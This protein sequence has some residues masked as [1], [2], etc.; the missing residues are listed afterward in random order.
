MF[1]K[2]G[3]K[4]PKSL[5]DAVSGVMEGK[6]DDLRDRMAEKEREKADDLSKDYTPKKKP[7]TQKVSGG[8]YGG[9]KQKSDDMDE[10][11]DFTGKLL[12]SLKETKEVD[13]D[14]EMTASQ[15][16]KREKIV[17]SMKDKQS[18]FKKKYGNRWKNV[19]YATATKM[20]MK[21]EKEEVD[22]DEKYDARKEHEYNMDAAQREIDRRHSQ[23]EDMTHAYVDKKTYEIKHKKPTKED[24]AD[25]TAIPAQNP[26]RPRLASS[27]SS[28]MPCSNLSTFFS[29][30][31]TVA[32]NLPYLYG[33]GV[34]WSDIV[35]YFRTG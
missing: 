6:I 11:Y 23:G 4:L 8:K 1:D 20:A 5:I 35:Y 27:R 25:T 17:L 28:S 13:E 22:L 21:E 2:F 26:P 18:E 31:S 32:T 10:N 24:T 9:T 19:M 15:K 30:D 14:D 12:K 7:I 16:K 33:S 34:N 3:Q 29:S